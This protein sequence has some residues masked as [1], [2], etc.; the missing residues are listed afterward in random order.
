MVPHFGDRMNLSTTLRPL[1]VVGG[2]AVRG[3]TLVRWLARSVF[4]RW[5]LF[6]GAALTLG[7]FTAPAKADFTDRWETLQAIHM[8]ENP[9]N[10]SRFGPHG[11]LG[12]YQFRRTTWK[13]YTT[14]SFRTALDRDESDRVA[15]KHYEWIKQGLRRNGIDPTA[16]HIALAWNAGLEAAIRGHIGAGSRSYAERV[17]TIAQDISRRQVAAQP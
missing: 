17:Q 1:G 15:V 8:V 10:S 9:T 16:Y 5:Q 4:G 7:F 6:V 2:S 12:P 13:Q 14:K 3:H 11:E